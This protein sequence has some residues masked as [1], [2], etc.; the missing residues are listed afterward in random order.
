[1]PRG[2]DQSFWGVD[3][4]IHL[5]LKYEPIEGTAICSP[6][7]AGGWWWHTEG[8]LYDKVDIPFLYR[9][10]QIHVALIHEIA[11]RE[12]L[13][14]QI[15]RFLEKGM[16]L[17]KDV[18]Q[19]SADEFSFAAIYD[20]MELLCEKWQAYGEAFASTQPDSYRRLSK[21]VSGGLNRLAF[22][23]SSPY[24]YD[25]TFPFKPF[26]GLYSVKNTFRSNT[27]PETFLFRQTQFVR[28]R[29]RLVQEL[30]RL[31]TMIEGARET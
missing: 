28:Q 11:E 4:P 26:P 19:H 25:H 21:L 8:D 18:D 27:T 14:I 29:N 6:G 2:A 15:S 5:G 22:S 24:D 7:C 10:T 31:T 9:D 23:Y 16:E 3:I 1:M 30:R 12:H 17:L 20:V 13:P